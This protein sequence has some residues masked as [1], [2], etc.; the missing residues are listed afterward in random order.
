MIRIRI[1]GTRKEVDAF[2]EKLSLCFFVSDISKSYQNSNSP[3]IRVY[4]TVDSEREKE[5]E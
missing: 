2:I 5:N 3:L 4:M 1:T